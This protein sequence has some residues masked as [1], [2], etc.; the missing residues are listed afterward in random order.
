VLAACHPCSVAASLKLWDANPDIATMK[1]RKPERPVL[2]EMNDKSGNPITNECDG[3]P[4]V[5]PNLFNR[6]PAAPKGVNFIDMPYA[7]DLTK[8]RP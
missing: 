1:V 5:F 7:P 6:I 2:L 8:R 3:Q 4:R